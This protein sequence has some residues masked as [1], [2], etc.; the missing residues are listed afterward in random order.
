MRLQVA[1][2]LCIPLFL[3]AYGG[4]STRSPHSGEPPKGVAVIETQSEG[5][6]TPLSIWI[7]GEETVA[8]YETCAWVVHVTGGTAPFTYNWWGGL[9]GSYFVLEGWLTQS[10]WE[11]VEVVDADQ[12]ADTAAIFIDVDDEYSC[13]YR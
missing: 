8:P 12:H 5:E 6:R 13:D 11:W 3:A 2:T 10:D 7:D 9:S 1:G 4:L